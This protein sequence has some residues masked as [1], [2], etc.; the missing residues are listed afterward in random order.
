MSAVSLPL[1][2][3]FGPWWIR[4]RTK[5]RRADRDQ[6]EHDEHEPDERDLVALEAHPE[7]LPG[8]ATF[9]VWHLISRIVC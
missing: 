8:S 3:S 6:D 4:A 1:E 7:E 5:T 9:D 2:S